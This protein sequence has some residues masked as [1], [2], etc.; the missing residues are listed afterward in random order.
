MKDQL[1]GGGGAE[2]CAD[3]FAVCVYCRDLTV[4][5][6]DNEVRRVG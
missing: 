5:I 6:N 4:L 1:S 3:C 2:R